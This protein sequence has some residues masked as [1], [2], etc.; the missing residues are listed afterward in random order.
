MSEQESL[1]EALGA[2]D[3]KF[4]FAPKS[5]RWFTRLHE[6]VFPKA[7]VI[8]GHTCYYPEREAAENP[9]A[10]MA[11]LIAHEGMHLAQKLDFGAFG[12]NWRYAYPQGFAGILG[13]FGLVVGLI[14]GITVGPLWGILAASGWMLPAIILAVN[15]KTASARVIFELE[16]YTT[17][18]LVLDI[19]PKRSLDD[20]KAFQAFLS[21]LENTLDS[22]T[23]LWCGR[24]VSRQEIANLLHKTMDRQ[25]TGELEWPC[26][27]YSREWIS[28][29]G[30]IFS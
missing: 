11:Q 25:F 14:F 28:T 6:R 7:A 23:Y 9:T 3:P 24:G 21:Y 12:W 4:T 18:L 10:Y 5:S 1:I 15:V 2:L 8:L 16:A 19:K 22:R 20:S 13:L 17:L 27:A 30:R 26:R 29:L